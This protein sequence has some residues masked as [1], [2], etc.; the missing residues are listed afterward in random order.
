MESAARGTLGGALSVVSQLPP[1]VG[2]VV[3]DTARLAFTHA[4]HAVSIVSA[5]IALAMALLAITVMRRRN[6]PA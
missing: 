3:T 5:A 1:D 4:L 6:K 2:M